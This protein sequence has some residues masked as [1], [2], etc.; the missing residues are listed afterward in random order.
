MNDDI[1][2]LQRQLAN[3]EEN[4]RLIQ[5]RKSEYVSEEEIPLQLI[6][7]ERKLVERIAELHQQLHAAGAE[8]N[9]PISSP[10]DL[11]DPSL[12]D[13]PSAPA[14]PELPDPPAPEPPDPPGQ[15]RGSPFVVGKPVQ[16]HQRLFGREPELRFIAG[17]LGA[18]RCV[19]I[20]GERRMGKTSLLNH[21]VGNWE[22]HKPL[23]PE[24]PPLLLAA[25]DLQ[26]NVT[27][28]TRFYGAALRE[29]LA[30]TSQTGQLLR[31]WHMRLQRQPVASYDEFQDALVR[32]KGLNEEIRVQPVLIVDEFERL[33]EPEMRT[34]FPYPHFFDNLR[35][36]IGHRSE[37]LVMVVASREPLERYFTDPQRP[38]GLTSSFPTYFQPRT[39]GPLK[40]AEADALLLQPSDHP[41]TPT[42]AAQARRWAGEHPC[43]LQ[44]AGAAWYQAKAEGHAPAQQW[45]Q[46]RYK[47]VQP[48]NCLVI[49]NP[50]NHLYY[51]SRQQ[52]PP[53]VQ[54]A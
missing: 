4:L 34:G 22:T 17:E 53:I 25:I 13:Q 29:L 54:R 6:K 41:L 16:A 3:A 48:Q 5:E 52:R 10:V 32:L 43:H 38:S 23:R 21:L 45:A 30:Q 15:P 24:L 31:E 51:S 11:P 40:P 18:N 49:P 50:G 19:N 37:L 26:A 12:P 1:T 39:L 20:I 7:N 9:S 47:E 44:V 2:S 14:P 46:K 36:L 33:L 35:S 8:S 42:E 27:D 28:A